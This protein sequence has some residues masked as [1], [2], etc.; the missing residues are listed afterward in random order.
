MSMRACGYVLQA[1]LR[2]W[3]P[4]LLRLGAENADIISI[5]VII[6]CSV[7]GSHL[8]IDCGGE[9]VICVGLTSWGSIRKNWHRNIL[10]FWSGLL[11]NFL[12]VSLRGGN[13]LVGWPFLI[14]ARLHMSLALTTWCSHSFAQ[15]CFACCKVLQRLAFAFWCSVCFVVRH[16][17]VCLRLQFSSHQSTP[18]GLGFYLGL[19]ISWLT[20]SIVCLKLQMRLSRCCWRLLAAI[21]SWQEA[22]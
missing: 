15:C 7:T 19:S 5:A 6:S 22:L 17:V 12:S 3:Y 1:Q 2:S 18:S 9:S 10:D 13:T 14:L 8:P 4:T 20:P 21:D 16:T 11:T